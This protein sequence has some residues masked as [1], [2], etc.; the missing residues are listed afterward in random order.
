MIGA[1]LLPRFHTMR[2]IFRSRCASTLKTSYVILRGRRST[3]DVSCC[4]FSANRN[5]SA[6]RSGDKVQIPWQAWHFV[7]CH[8]NRRRFLQYVHKKTRR[9]TL[10]LVLRSVICCAYGKSLKNVSFRR[11]RRCAHV[12]LRGRCGTL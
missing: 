4:V 9:K 12:V 2:R 7:T 5:V 11:V 10:I 1:I 3:L 8:E 6:A